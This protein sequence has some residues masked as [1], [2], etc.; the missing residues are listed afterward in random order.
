MRPDLTF[1][2]TLPVAQAL[3]R[4]SKKPQR[5]RQVSEDPTYLERV[6][7][8]YACLKGPHLHHLD[9]SAPPQAVHAALLNL[10]LEFLEAAGGPVSGDR[11]LVA[12]GGIKLRPAQAF[13]GGCRRDKGSPSFPAFRAA[14]SLDKSTPRG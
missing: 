14:D 8:I 7:A 10:T 1:I 5:A 6:A 11:G 12:P 9:A 3:A 4:L 13:E 2:L